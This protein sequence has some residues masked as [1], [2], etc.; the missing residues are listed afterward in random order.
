MFAVLRVRGPIGIR[1]DIKHNLELLNLTRVSH[2]VIYPE[3]D[4][5]KGMLKKGKDYI[6]WG[7][8]S[9][10]ILVKILTKR[11]KAYREDGKLVK[12]PEIYKDINKIAK[13]IMESKKTTKEL[14]IKPVFRLKAPTK[15]YDRKGIKKTFNEGGV[16]GYRKEKINSLLNRMI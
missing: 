8:I 4:K 16:L 15:G 12:V 14:K 6:T 7:E 10:E 1:K 3:T 11:G 9:E 2:C 13:E 5:I